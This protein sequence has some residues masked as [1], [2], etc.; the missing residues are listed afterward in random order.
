M[1]NLL[2]WFLIYFLII[3]AATAIVTCYDKKAA[4]KF[5]RHRVSEA[6]LFLLALIGGAVAEF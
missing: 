5:P 3:S 1:I 6:M 2:K 4:V